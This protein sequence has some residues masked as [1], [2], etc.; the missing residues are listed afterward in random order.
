MN[1]TVSWRRSA[2]ALSLAA[3]RGVLISQDR[4]ISCV[5]FLAT[6]LVRVEVVLDF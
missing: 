1:C 2:L 4:A 5:A 6:R 3:R